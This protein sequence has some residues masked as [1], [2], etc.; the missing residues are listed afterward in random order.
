MCER[1]KYEKDLYSKG[2]KYIIGLDEAGRGPMAGPLVVAGVILPVGYYDDRIND[3][4]QLSARKREQLY[5]IIIENAIAYNIQVISVEE[6]D[7]LNVYQ[8]S[9]TGMLRAIK[10]I[11]IKPDYAL[12]DAMPLDTS[13]ECTSIIKGDAKSISIASASILAKVTRDHL[14]EEYDHI[15]PQYNF[16]KHKGYPTKEHKELLKKYGVSPI[17]RKS[18]K[19]VQDIL[20]VQLKLDI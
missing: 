19:P 17:H 20:N 14:M 18:F 15:Y 10:E 13:I 3:S 1:L 8:A 5:D 12:S 6:V 7:K 16:K 2:Y 9:K 4:K 11:N